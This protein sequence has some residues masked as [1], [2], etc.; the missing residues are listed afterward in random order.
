MKPQHF[1]NKE[2]NENKELMY[3]FTF[4][5]YVYINAFLCSIT[6]KCLHRSYTLEFMALG[7]TLQ[8]PVKTKD[9][10]N[11]EWVTFSSLL[12][13]VSLSLPCVIHPGE[14]WTSVTA[15]THTWVWED[16]SFHRDSA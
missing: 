9:Y 10:L 14:T 2:I 4:N 6:R 5:W 16:V 15:E 12:P 8:D 13:D 7:K 11:I 3:Q 1:A